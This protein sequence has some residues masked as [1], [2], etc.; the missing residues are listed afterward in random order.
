MALLHI[1]GPIVL[2]IF[3]N[4]A[5]AGLERVISTAIPFPA[6]K[7]RPSSTILMVSA[8]LP[9]LFEP[10]QQTR[11]P[12]QSLTLKLLEKISQKLPRNQTAAFQHNPF[13]DSHET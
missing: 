12:S 1:S 7:R 4:V 6:S 9:K 3:R 13:K 10:N 11:V 5:Y 2:A 8:Q